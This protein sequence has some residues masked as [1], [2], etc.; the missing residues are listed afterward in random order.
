LAPGQVDH[1]PRP[2]AGLPIDGRFVTAPIPTFDQLRA[3]R[4]KT[5][6]LSHGSA[7]PM[8]K[9][10]RI[11]LF[12][13]WYRARPVPTCFPTPLSRSNLPDFDTRSGL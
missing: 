11:A 2:R 1:Q 12:Q 6:P 4:L 3:R 8:S 10:E 5:N 13:T 7:R 9:R